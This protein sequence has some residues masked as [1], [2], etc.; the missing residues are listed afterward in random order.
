MKGSGI[1]PA[2]GYGKDQMKDLEETIKRSGAE[3]VVIGTPIDLTKIVKFDIPATRVTYSLKE[4]EGG[5][6]DEI[7]E[8]FLAKHS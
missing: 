7:I 1:L 2:M 6:L 8:Q 3:A 5:N 4:K